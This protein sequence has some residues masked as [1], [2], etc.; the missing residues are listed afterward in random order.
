MV[1][2]SCCR[3]IYVAFTFVFSLSVS[4]STVREVCFDSFTNTQ[5][6]AFSRKN[7][8]LFYF[9][10]N[11]TAFKWSNVCYKK[12]YIFISINSS[13]MDLVHWSITKA[14]SNRKIA[15]LHISIHVF[16]LLIGAKRHYS[17]RKSSVK[18]RTFILLNVQSINAKWVCMCVIQLHPTFR[19]NKKY[20]YFVGFHERFKSNECDVSSFKLYEFLNFIL[21]KERETAIK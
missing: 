4:L 10:I 19:W 1:S 15:M 8:I 12:I 14:I 17:N 9:Q 6:H 5:T 7:Q 21:L 20:N 18:Y 13:Q 11:W 16:R 3:P 2:K